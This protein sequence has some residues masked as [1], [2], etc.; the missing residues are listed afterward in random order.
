MKI[1]I[2][3]KPSYWTNLCPVVQ[4]GRS[5]SVTT[6]RYDSFIRVPVTN[7]SPVPGTAPVP[8]FG[9]RRRCI[10]DYCLLA[11]SALSVYHNPQ[12]NFISPW[13]YHP[14]KCHSPLQSA[15]QL[16]WGLLLSF[17]F[18]ERVRRFEHRVATVAQSS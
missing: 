17:L 10:E 11:Y 4:Y 8:R 14:P 1:Y 9:A 3:S 7:T 2:T 15:S 6:V 18:P 16:D 5:T 12:D 13:E